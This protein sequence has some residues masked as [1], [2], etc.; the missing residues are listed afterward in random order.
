MVRTNRLVFSVVVGWALAASAAVSAA[1]PP[2]AAQLEFFETRIRPILVE[3]CYACHNSAKLAEG[4][5]AADSRDAVL[6][7]GSSGKVLVPGKPADSRLLAILRHEVEGVKMPQGLGKLEATVIA[8]FEKWIEM[9]APDPRDQAPTDAEL[10]KTTSWEAMLA[11]RKLWWSFQP[12][13][14]IPAPEIPDNRW[15][16]DPI[17]RFVLAKLREQQLE[18]VAPADASTLVRRLYFTLIGLPPTAD[19]VALWSAKVQQPQ[20]DAELVD[21]LLAS[22]HFGEQWARHWMDWIRYADSHGSEGDPAIDNGWH[23]RDYL[24]RALNSDV[25]YDQLVREQIAG[26]LLEQPRINKQLGINESLIGPAHWRMVFHGFA[27]TD[28]LD[29]KV[30]FID[31]EINTFSKAFLGLTVSCARCHDHKFDPISQQDYYALFGILGSCRPG[32]VAIDLPEKLNANRE[33]LTALKPQIRAAIAAE[34]LAAAP[35]VRAQ[36]LADDGPW[37]S[38]ESPKLVLHPLYQLRKAIADGAAFP[39]AWK[40]QL[41]AWSNERRQREEQAQRKSWKRWNLTAPEDYSTWF[42]IGTALSDRP[43]LP[44]EFALSAA[45]EQVLTG[46]YPAGVYSHRLSAKH[47]ARLSSGYVRLDGDY[48]LWV[49]VIGEGGASVRY[50]VQDY[51]R[52]GTV[53]PVIQLTPEWTWQKF[54]LTYWNGDDIHVEITAGLDAPL[55]VNNSPRSWFGIREAVIIRKGNPVPAE[56]REFLDPLFELSADRPPESLD[57]VVDHYVVSI[58]SAVKAWQAGSATDV[59]VSLLQA[60]MKQGLLP[61]TLEGLPSASPLVA[62]YRRLE[63]A[64][65][66][67]TRVPGLEETQGRDQHLFTRGNHKQPGELVPRRF[68]E[69]I[70]A[71]PYRTTQSGRLQLAADLLRDDNPLTRRVIVNRLWHHLFG[72]GLVPTPDN[73]GR[74]GHEPT[75]P[76]LIDYLATEFKTQGWSLKSAIRSMVLSKTW[77]LASLP[78]ARAS[79]VDPDNR[80]LSHAHVRRLEAESIRDSLLAVS[81][82]LLP[83]QFGPPV[84]GNAN[85]RSVYVRVQRNAL[86]PFLRAFDFPEPFTTTGRR[87]TTNVPA[88]SL[89][90]L[91]DPRVAELAAAWAASVLGDKQLASDEARIQGMFVKAFGRP[92]Q[93]AELGKLQAYLADTQAGYT[94]VAEQI[95]GLREQ[96]SRRQVAIGKLLDPVRTRLIEQARSKSAAG[97]QVVPQPVSRWEFDGDLQDR[98]GSAHGAA[99]GGARV[100]G[101][102]LILNPQAHVITAPIKQNL[103]AKTLEAWVQLSTLDQ[104]GGGVMTIQTPDGVVFDAIVFAEQAPRQWLAGSDGFSRTQPFQGPADQDAANQAVHL[105]ITYH[106]DGRIVGYRN[107]QPYG[108]SYQ[109][110]GPFEFKAGSAVVGFGIRHLPAGGNRMLAGRILRAQLYDRALTADEIQATSQSAPYFVTETQVLA[111]ISEADRATV[112][113]ERQQIRA[114]ELEI[115]SLGP[116]PERGD[117]RAAWKELAQTLFTFKEFLYVK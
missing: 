3:K 10:T 100:E 56:S 66:V 12:I 82:R 110:Q 95:A 14:A 79:Q 50:V 62:E 36:L 8:D 46:I 49:R 92:A 6:K 61:N 65:V 26:D 81:G 31:D 72:R 111:A 112:A 9:G 107:G 115:E 104:S 24:I 86:D 2:T 30:R 105:A 117:Q 33:Q 114:L 22:P 21:H 83:E 25:P 84:E 96:V 15:S 48:E 73:F 28:A 103:K 93:A 90:M 54:D 97:E 18:P 7:G 19:E 53:F 101:G 91:N 108:R 70:D 67:P 60:C 75:H 74:L 4:E 16:P 23:F 27:P 41:D 68:L 40:G 113:H 38:A 32:R 45:P 59:Q 39:A 52:N 17:D 58:T 109:S 88:Q 63:E 47:A 13:R 102:A 77:Q 99:R 57:Q 89:T 71:T 76:E 116:V 35:R 43:S 51:P 85:R 44:G 1:E 78:S 11:K 34:W 42:R 106:E 64:I 98:I 55:M 87:D 94:K 5:F 20:G 69:A 29:E 37:K 80:L